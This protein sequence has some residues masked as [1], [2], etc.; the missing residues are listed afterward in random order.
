MGPRG[1]CWVHSHPAPLMLGFSW[2]FLAAQSPEGRDLL[3][4]ISICCR[5]CLG[6]AEGSSFL[7]LGNFGVP[8]PCVPQHPQCPVSA[9][10]LPWESFGI[11]ASLSMESL[12]NLCPCDLS[13]VSHSILSAQRVSSTF[14]ARFCALSRTYVYRLLLGCAHRSQIPVFEQ[15]L[16]WAPPGG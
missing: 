3:E 4:S 2:I 13:L 12:W 15:D 8:V 6:A 16:C 7:S 5:S 11:S 9:L 1:F 10:H 14:H